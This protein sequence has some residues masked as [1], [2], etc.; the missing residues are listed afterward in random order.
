MMSIFYLKYVISFFK[1]Y[2][3]C[4]KKIISNFIHMKDEFWENYA[5]LHTQY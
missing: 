2:Q 4:I 1:G 5:G 3:S